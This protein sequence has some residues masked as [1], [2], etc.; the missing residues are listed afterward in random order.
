MNTKIVDGRVEQPG[1]VAA[2]FSDRGTTQFRVGEVVYLTDVEVRDRAIV[3]D[4]VSRDI[5]PIIERRETSQM[6][7]KGQVELHF[8][9]AFLERAGLDE[10]TDAIGEFLDVSGD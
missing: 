5:R 4:L 9:P 10:I 6:R 3:L 7:Y 8:A 1:G 2:F